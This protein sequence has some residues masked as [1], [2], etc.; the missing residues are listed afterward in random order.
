MATVFDY[1]DMHDLGETAFRSI[2]GKALRDQRR[3]LRAVPPSTWDPT[4]SSLTRQAWGYQQHLM[5]LM[6]EVPDMGDISPAQGAADAT[7]GAM[8]T[9]KE[10][11]N[12]DDETISTCGK[13]MAVSALVGLVAG[14]VGLVKT[15]L[16]VGAVYLISEWMGR[17]A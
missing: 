3:R 7:R 13:A 10:K 12:L 14:K 8:A 1:G 15:V 6:G 2:Q 11:L 16:G 17:K 4:A 9:V 5:D